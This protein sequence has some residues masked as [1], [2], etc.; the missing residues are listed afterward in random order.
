M[1][2]AGDLSLRVFVKKLKKYGIKVL[3]RKGK[4]S[5]IILLKPNFPDSRQGPQYPIKNHGDKTMI[6]RPVIKAALRRFGID[7]N[8]FWQK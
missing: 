2:N 5:E 7:E 8:D 4:G 1:S 6:K 3:T